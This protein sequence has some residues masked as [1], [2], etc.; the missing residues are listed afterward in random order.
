MKLEIKGLE[1]KI[2][3]KQILKGID[4][5]IRTGEIHALMGPNGSGK[6]TLAN[7]IMG[8][9]AYEV[10]GGSVTLEGEN[11]SKGGVDLLKEGVDLLG[12]RPTIE[13]EEEYFWLS[14][15]P[16]RLQELL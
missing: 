12:P 4:L 13:P 8:D 2:E 15:T 6:S 1:A 5:Q 10:T 7:V 11:L 9:P 3:G 16:S 14:N